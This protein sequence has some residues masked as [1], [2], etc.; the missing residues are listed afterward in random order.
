MAINMLYGYI[1]DFIEI[2]TLVDITNTKVAR[3][4]QGTQLE[5]DQN[6]NFATLLQC[7]ELR[8][9]ISYDHPPSVDMIDINH[10]KF[11]DTYTGKHK[12]WTF[13]FIPDRTDV[14]SNN[15]RV[16]GLLDDDIDGVPII[17]NL[18]ETINMIKAIFNCKDP[19]S[20]NTI[21]KAQSGTL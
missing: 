5:Y 20:K 13:T 19:F 2:K 12:V 11:G 6:R 15:D 9:I 7:V 16:T 1:M 21:I 3:P 17:K 14:F 4:N 10:L 8:S 18:T